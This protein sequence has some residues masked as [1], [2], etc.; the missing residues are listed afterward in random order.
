MLVSS[1]HPEQI[2]A[3]IRPGLSHLLQ[4]S[5][6]NAKFEHASIVLQAFIDTW[7]LGS[8]ISVAEQRWKTQCDPLG[9]AVLCRAREV[10]TLLSP[11]IPE[12]EL[13]KDLPPHRVLNGDMLAQSRAELC[14]LAVKGEIAGVV[15]E[16][17]VPM[18][19][20]SQ[21]A[22]GELCME[23][24]AQ[25]AVLRYGAAGLLAPEAPLFEDTLG[26][27]PE[28]RIGPQL[29]RM[30]DIAE[31]PGTPARLKGGDT[32]PVGWLLWNGPAKP[33]P[34]TDT[35]FQLI[36]GIDQGFEAAVEQAEISVEDAQGII[37]ELV[38]LGVLSA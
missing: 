22:L 20:A 23:A 26:R 13:P 21:L 35:V 19:P 4:D 3:F 29:K 7:P 17:P 5:I 31:L 36:R 2:E 14:A 16:T 34:V 11:N 33:L 25:T 1:F 30:C 8:I 18:E 9:L 12:I 15:F 10:L 32:R 28:G 37:R 6:E 38:Q 24:P 27:A